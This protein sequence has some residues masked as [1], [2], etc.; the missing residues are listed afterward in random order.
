[1]EIP[2]IIKEITKY[3]EIITK[4]FN[5]EKSQEELTKLEKITLEENFWNKDD[6]NK[7]MREKD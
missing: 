7:I 2:D 5:L 1:M 3:L 6:A 4:V